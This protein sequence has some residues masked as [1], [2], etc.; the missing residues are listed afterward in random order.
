M[1]IYVILYYM[2]AKDMEYPEGTEPRTAYYCPDGMYSNLGNN[3][4]IPLYN[5]ENLKC[6]RVEAFSI[7]E[8]YN[9][10][11]AT[12]P[13]AVIVGVEDERV[14]NPEIAVA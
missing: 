5:S 11:F 2:T 10:F 14:D 3:R 9:K 6:D 13:T 1:N 12:N 4:T 7:P 8:A